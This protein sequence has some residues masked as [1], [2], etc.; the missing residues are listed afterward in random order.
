LR[1]HPFS[2]PS[3]DELGRDLLFAFAG[4]AAVELPVAARSETRAERSGGVGDPRRT[5]IDTVF[6]DVS[7]RPIFAGASQRETYDP[8][9]DM[10]LL[11]GPDGSDAPDRIVDFTAAD[12][13]G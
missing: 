9:S 2:N 5:G 4:S 13:V 11:Q 3:Y 1:R 6:A 10:P 12:S 8:Q 7:E